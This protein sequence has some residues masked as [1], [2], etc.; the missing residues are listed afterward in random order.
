MSKLTKNIIFN[1]LGQGT[2]MA[3]GFVAVRYIYRGLGGDALGIIYFAL[4]AS[5]IISAMLDLGIGSSAI[6]EVS[7]HAKSEPEYVADFVRTG[8]LF[9]W[10][11]YLLL[12]LAIYLCAPAIVT[13]WIKL[14]TLD[15]ETAIRVLRV[16]GMA[17]LVALPRTLYVGV[18]RGLQRMEFNNVIDVTASALQ[19]FGTIVILL[20]GGGLLRVVHWFAICYSASIA[21][22]ILTCSAFLSRRAMVPSFSLAVVKR[23]FNFASNMAAASVLSIVESQADK[24]IVSKLLPIGMFGYY[25]VAYGAVSKGMLITGSI[26]DAAL[27]SLCELHGNGNTKALFS[28]YN[29]LQDLLC[30]VTLPIVAAI[31]FAALPVF[32]F[33]L[34]AEVARLLLLPTTFL[35]LGSYLNSTLQAPHMFSLAAG[36]PDITARFNLYA[37]FVVPPTAIVL[38]HFFGLNGAGFSWVV[39][40]LFSYAY[41]VPRICKEC[42]LGI[43]PTQLYAHVFR[44]L[45]PAAILYGL[46]WTVCRTAGHASIASLVVGYVLASLVFACG[47]FLLLGPDL[48]CTFQGMVRAFRAKH[49]EAF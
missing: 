35:C 24:I 14:K 41:A 37:L 4:T 22:Y 26:A 6:R 15:L 28:Q 25:G 20:S 2:L 7:S 1:L 43:T 36:R 49:V 19:Q 32:T 31:P 48:R 9:F 18:L 46:A 27:P 40:N 17:S 10:G 42:G 38:I 44:F 34:N 8:S 12:A 11:V 39:Y 21:A 29:K 45:G 5:T 3:L 33:M 16:I 47:S 13:H 23:N 30:F